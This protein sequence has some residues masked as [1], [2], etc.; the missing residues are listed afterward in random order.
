MAKGPGPGSATGTPTKKGI[1]DAAAADVGPGG[2][3]G[4]KRGRKPKV[5][6]EDGYL[7][8]EVQGAVDGGDEARRGKKRRVEGEREGKENFDVVKEEGFVK[9]EAEVEWLDL[10]L[11]RV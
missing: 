2:T 4:R 9:G 5:K 1:A 10:G 7:A 8:V 11:E 6:V 3:P